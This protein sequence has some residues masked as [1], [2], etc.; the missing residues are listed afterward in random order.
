[1]T[2]HIA[3]QGSLAFLGIALILVILFQ[4]A[5]TAPV[6]VT[7]VTVP[8]AGG[9]YIEGVLGYSETINPILAPSMISANP[10]D[11]DL[12][13]LVFDGLAVLDET[14]QV[15]PSLATGWEVSEDGSVYEFHLRR[16]VVW[17]DGA[18]FTAADVAFTVQAMQDPNFQGDPSLG[19]LWR[20]VTVEQLDNYTVRFTLEEPF[21][22]FLQ[23]TTIGLLPAHLLSNVAAADLP[24]HAFST[25][26]PTGTGMFMLESVSPDRVVLVSNPNYWKAKPYLER[27]EFWFYANWEGLLEDYERGAIQGFHP[28]NLQ[29]LESLVGIPSLQLYSA[30]SAG[31]GLVYLNLGRESLPFFQAREVRQA[32]LYALDREALI[33]QVLGGQGLVADSPILPTTWAYD[34]SVRQ[35]GYDPER[36]IGLL[37]ASGWMDS[38]GDLI[39]DRDGVELAFTLLTND[40]PTEVQMAEEIARQWRVVGVDV[41]IRSVSSESAVYFVRNR[42][43]D[44]A[45]VAIELTG[46]PDPYP[47]WHSTQA[48]NGQNFAGFANAEADAVMEEARL[49]TDT[50]RR[51]E[52]YYRFQ[53][54][55][56]EEVPSL[57]IYYPIYTYAVDIQVQDVQLS[58]MLH[59]S[60][61]FRNIESWYVQTEETTVTETEALDNSGE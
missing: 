1:M 57:L 34:A 55:F 7:T 26:N 40:D 5:S 49:T 35:Y 61:R 20:N 8:I 3:W 29:A 15:S 33:A 27:I 47:L 6:E 45:L 37:D 16:D 30:Q 9:T 22:S 17:H 12:S 11:Q 10:V 48:E 54:I 51:L 36:A 2:R 59:T 42:N 53:Q 31:Y 52:L 28:P 25:R 60:D 56:A 39:R 41:T 18:P 43:F 21:P 58:P 23:Y 4:M 24:S 50:E 13:A 32:L 19:E 14:G 44:S 38:D 46:D